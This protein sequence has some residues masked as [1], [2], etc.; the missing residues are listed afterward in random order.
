MAIPITGYSTVGVDFNYFANWPIYFD[1][2]SK[3]GIVG[4]ESIYEPLF[5]FGLQRYNTVYDISYPVMVSIVDPYAF[6]NRGYTFRFALEAN[7][8]NN[9]IIDDSFEALE[10]IN[11]PFNTMLCDRNKRNSGNITI[12][13]VDSMTNKPIDNVSVMYTIGDETCIIGTTK[14]GVLT[15]NFPVAFNGIVIFEHDNYLGKSKILSTRLYENKELDDVKLYRKKALS[16]DIKKKIVAPRWS[17]ID[18][19]V[20][21]EKNESVFVTLRRINKIGEKDHEL[22]FSYNNESVMQ[23]LIP[24]NYN[25]DIS[26]MKEKEFTILPKKRCVEVG[27]FLGALIPKSKTCQTI[28]SE[29]MIMQTLTNGGY[30]GNLT[31]S[32]SDVYDNNEMTL[33]IVSPDLYAIPINDRIIEDLEQITS[34]TTYSTIFKE[35][36]SPVFK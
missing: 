23:E 31:I 5:S 26:F 34:I 27:G 33:F 1:I 6:N 21:L 2:N 32:E 20:E 18:D 22:V 11:V 19:S 8:R 28:P 16:I 14:N 3:G 9:E 36:L 35:Q 13:I 10:A 7:I 15:E 25:V 30:V 12:N 17:F 4:P 24:G 29:P